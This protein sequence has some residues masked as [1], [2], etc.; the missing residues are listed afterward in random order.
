MIA[1]VVNTLARWGV[2]SIDKT[3]HVWVKSSDGNFSFS[4]SRNLSCQSLH[5]LCQRY[6]QSLRWCKS[7]EKA[8]WSMDGKTCKVPKPCDWTLHILKL[9]YLWEPPFH[10]FCAKYV[11]HW[12][13]LSAIAFCLFWSSWL[14]E[15]AHMSNVFESFSG[16]QSRLHATLSHLCMHGS[17]KSS[18]P[19]T[20]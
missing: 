11:F 2:W 10:P 9:W 4:C 19:P 18:L 20:Q 3:E 1:G 8:A 17:L 12:L 5:Y 7:Q 6:W 15:T 13:R 14:I 16:F